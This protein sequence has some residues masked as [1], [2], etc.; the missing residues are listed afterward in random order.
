[1]RRVTLPLY[2]M[3]YAQTSSFHFS[4]IA[5]PPSGFQFVR[6]E[7]WRPREARRRS[8]VDLFE[9]K[10]Q[11]PALSAPALRLTADMVASPVTARPTVAARGGIPRSSPAGP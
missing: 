6:I 9:W 4:V 10:R 7:N 8:C 2:Q 3:S 5:C 11:P 1:V